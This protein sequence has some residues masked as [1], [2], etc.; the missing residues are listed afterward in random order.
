MFRFYCK[1]C[2]LWESFKISKTSAKLLIL[3]HS[4]TCE[5]DRVRGL[6]TDP[7]VMRSS[8]AMGHNTLC[9]AG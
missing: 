5:R 3:S 6:P 4:S 1:K 2:V 7:E 8:P 9:T